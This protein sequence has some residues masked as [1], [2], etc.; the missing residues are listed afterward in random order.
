MIS[1]TQ[2][3]SKFSYTWLHPLHHCITWE[4]G[5]PLPFIATEMTYGLMA[6]LLSHL[7]SEG[8]K[9]NDSN[10]SYIPM[11][12][13]NLSLLSV[14]QSHCCGSALTPHGR[15]PVSLRWHR[16]SRPERNLALKAMWR[17]WWN[18]LYW[19]EWLKGS[20][21]LNQSKPWAADGTHPSL[22]VQS[23]W[24]LIP[25]VMKSCWC[26]HVLSDVPVTLESR[27]KSDD[28]KQFLFFVALSF[29]PILDSNLHY[30]YWYMEVSW[31]GGTSTPRI[32]H[33]NRDFRISI[34]NHT[35]WVSTF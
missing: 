30:Y 9:G 15:S 31:N 22:K 6:H 17:F 27:G 2:H 11:T 5:C 16:P 32:I 8:P 13:Q 24:F 23:L 12:S 10:D 1:L 20:N 26:Y 14:S 18:T 21:G 4:S 34:I 33:F 35:F 28:S 25:F 29:L 3:H 19:L 7:K